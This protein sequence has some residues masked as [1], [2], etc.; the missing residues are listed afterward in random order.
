M[1]FDGLP[2]GDGRPVNFFRNAFF[3][4]SVLPLPD[5]KTQFFFEVREQNEL[6]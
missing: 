1:T 3:F 2:R 5:G 4:Q 6:R